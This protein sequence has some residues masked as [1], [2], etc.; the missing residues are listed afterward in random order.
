MFFLCNLLLFIS[1]DLVCL[2]SKFIMNIVNTIFASEIS[3][4]FIR[5]PRPRVAATLNPALRINII[6]FYVFYKHQICITK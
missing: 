3:G 4:I 2:N 6:I 1:I 5:A